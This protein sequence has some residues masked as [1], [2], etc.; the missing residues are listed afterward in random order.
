MGATDDSPG[1][2]G[3]AGPGA[4]C[5]EDGGAEV[6]GCCCDDCW[7]EVADGCSGELSVDFSLD[8]EPADGDVGPAEEVSVDADCDSGDV[9]SGDVDSGDFDSGDSGGEDEGFDSEVEGD[10]GEDDEGED[11]EDELDDD[12]DEGED[13]D[14]EGEADDEDELGEDE[15]DVDVDGLG[16]PDVERQGNGVAPGVPVAP[17]GGHGGGFHGWGNSGGLACWSRRP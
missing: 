16:L 12:G 17:G 14:E 3:V 8:G 2:V 11:D 10:E 1:V 6:A 4:D 7:G 15:V 5:S 13:E 9:D